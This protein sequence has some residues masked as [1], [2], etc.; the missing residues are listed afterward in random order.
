[1]KE[2]ALLR[3][4]PIKDSRDWMHA[5]TIRWGSSFDV[6]APLLDWTDII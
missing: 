3:L 1:M 5:D 4:P 2:E 6:P